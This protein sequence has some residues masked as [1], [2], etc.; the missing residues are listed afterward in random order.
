MNLANKMLQPCVPLLL[1][2]ILSLNLIFNWPTF[3]FPVLNTF[4]YVYLK[5]PKTALVRRNRIDSRKVKRCALR[6][7]KHFLTIA[8]LVTM[9]ILN[10]FVVRF[11]L[12]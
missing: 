7:L 10:S 9:V 4:F 2:G 5:T 12:A 8:N 11:L 3:S 1:L 6:V